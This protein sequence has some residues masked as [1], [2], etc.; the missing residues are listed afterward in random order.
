MGT[1]AENSKQ[2]INIHTQESEFQKSILFYC[3]STFLKNACFVLF[4]TFLISNYNAWFF[5]KVKFKYLKNK[6]LPRRETK[7]GFQSLEMDKRSVVI[8]ETKYEGS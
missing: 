7:A 5:S 8:S 4:F 1:D 3:F 6:N 2:V